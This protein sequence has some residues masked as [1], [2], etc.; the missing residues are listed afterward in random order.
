MGLVE[1]GKMPKPLTSLLNTA[2]SGNPCTSTSFER[3]TFLPS[4]FSAITLP[5]RL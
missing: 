2:P 3:V 4:I 5:L 1:S